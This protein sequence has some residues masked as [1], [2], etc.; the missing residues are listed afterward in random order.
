MSLRAA[1]TRKRWTFVELR[2]PRV[3]EHTISLQAVLIV[4]HIAAFH[5]GFRFGAR[6]KP[7]ADEALN[8]L[9]AVD[10]E[11]VMT[12]IDLTNQNTRPLAERQRR[13]CGLAHQM[14]DGKPQGHDR[15]LG[16]EEAQ[17]KQSRPR[18]SE[19]PDPGPYCA[20]TRPS[21]PIVDRAFIP[22]QNPCCAARAPR[23]AWQTRLPRRCRFHPDR[24]RDRP[25]PDCR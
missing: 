4:Q 2:R 25:Y 8:P 12:A 14:V 11:D 19:I 20:S 10:R 13:K 24:S 21:K 6:D 22:R 23:T 9:I 5:P 17:T 15:L 16:S 18:Y 1:S 7:P 3:E